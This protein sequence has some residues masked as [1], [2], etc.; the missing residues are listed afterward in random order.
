MDCWIVETQAIS[1]FNNSN[2]KEHKD[3]NAMVS[4]LRMHINL[5]ENEISWLLCNKKIQDP[6][7]DPTLITCTYTGCDIIIT[8]KS[9]QKE[10]IKLVHQMSVWVDKGTSHGIVIFIKVL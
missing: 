5:I 9:M 6:M 1:N 4:I 3:L 8:S 2:I 7:T 10:H